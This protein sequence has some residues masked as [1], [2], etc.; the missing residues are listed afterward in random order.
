M[1]R[2]VCESYLNYMKDFNEKDHYRYELM[3]PFSLLVNLDM[4][5]KEK[6]EQTVNYKKL[7]DFI[8]F[9][10]NSIHFYPNFKSFLWSLESRGIKGAY[11]GILTKEELN[12]QIKITN[13]FLKLTYWN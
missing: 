3:L 1:Y 11:Y 12:E 8:Y 13:M 4:Y 7:E 6:R 5:K 9:V 10:K 2:I